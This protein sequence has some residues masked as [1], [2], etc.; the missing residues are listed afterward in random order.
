M[1]NLDEIAEKILTKCKNGRRARGVFVVSANVRSIAVGDSLNE[2][3]YEYPRAF[4]G[5]YNKRCPQ[6]WLV[7]DIRWAMARW[8]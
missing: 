2:A 5:I 4:I 3:M 8:Q 6:K 7:D 1:M